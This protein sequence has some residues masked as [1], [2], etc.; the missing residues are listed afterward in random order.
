MKKKMFTLS[1]D[2]N[3]LQD[4]RLVELLNKY[5]LKC[6]FNVNS[7]IFSDRTHIHTSCGV[8]FEHFHIEPEEVKLIRHLWDLTKK[9]LL[10][11]LSEIWKLFRLLSVTR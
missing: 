9:D 10:K 8:T 5:G 3:V 7:G 1:Y 11:R 4:K 2:D 6:T